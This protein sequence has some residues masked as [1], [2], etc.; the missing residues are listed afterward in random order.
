MRRPAL[1]R[2]P[3][4]GRFAAALEPGVIAC[5]GTISDPRR[6]TMK[7]WLLRVLVNLL[8][9]LMVG[10]IVGEAVA[11][12]MMYWVVSDGRSQQNGKIR[13][14]NLDGSGVETLVKGL[15]SPRGIALDLPG[16]KM[17]W[18]AKHPQLIQGANL[19]GSALETL[20]MPAGLNANGIA[21]AP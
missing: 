4:A 2:R 7:R 5:F 17:Y 21:L 8:V 19:D 14:A 12:G 3:L 13:R 11:G 9:A 6:I 15:H 1:G 20:V 10:C 18:T 16:G